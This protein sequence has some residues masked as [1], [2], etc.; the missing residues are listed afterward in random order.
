[1]VSW[2]SQLK[3]LRKLRIRMQML[4]VERQKKVEVMKAAT[5]RMVDRREKSPMMMVLRLVLCPT[6]ALPR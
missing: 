5:N 4:K 3:P 2:V 1:M 6:L